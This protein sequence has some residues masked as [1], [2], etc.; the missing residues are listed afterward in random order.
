MGSTSQARVKQEE[1]PKVSFRVIQVDEDAK[2]EH[3]HGKQN[4]L[5]RALFDEY[6]YNSRNEKAWSRPKHYTRY[7][8]ET[9]LVCFSSYHSSM[10]AY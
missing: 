8:G 3:Q 5:T 6:G 1:I 7:I 10:P 9:R 2:W 4:N